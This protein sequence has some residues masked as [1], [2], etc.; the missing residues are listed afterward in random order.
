M[1]QVHEPILTL[2]GSASLR[3]DF[4]ECYNQLAAVGVPLNLVV[5]Y[6]DVPGKEGI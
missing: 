3:S 2:D 6:D 5:C 1:L 4:E